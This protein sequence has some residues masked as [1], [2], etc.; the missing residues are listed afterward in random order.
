MKRGTTP[1]ITFTLPEEI[2]IAELYITFSQ[3]K[4]TVLEKKLDDVEINENV[5]TL[6]LTQE[7]T[8]AFYAP[9]PVYI[10]LR[11]RDIGGNAIA[12][13]IIRT[14]VDGILKDGVI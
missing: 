4:R 12:S 8:L 5:I 10:Q 7:N 9:S 14:D 1:T 6:P 2:N 3:N 11:I 13:D